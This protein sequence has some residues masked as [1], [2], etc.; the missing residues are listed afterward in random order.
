MSEVKTEQYVP[1]LKQHYLEK[2][3]PELEEQFGYKNVM[4]V[5][6]LTKIMVSMGLGEVRDNPDALEAA[7]E[8]LAIITGQ[9]PAVRRAKKSVAAFRVRTGMPIGIV[10][11]LRG[12]RMWE[13]L[14][15]LINVALP[16]IRDFRGLSNNSFDGHGNYSFGLKDQ[17]IF[18]E[19]DYDKLDHIRGLNV[20][21]VTDA[22]TDE[23]G[24]ALLLGLGMPLVRSS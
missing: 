17:T 9:K 19:I 18:P 15:R 22:K 1:R 8:Q 5:P 4:A 14:D 11:T 3:V 2:V 16:R 24:R 20:T 12:V 6:K 10:V 23:E 21:L 7:M 13:F